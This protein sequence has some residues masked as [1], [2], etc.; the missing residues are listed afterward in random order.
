[1]AS[2]HRTHFVFMLLM[3]SFSTR[4]GAAEAQGA[5][6]DTIIAAAQSLYDAL[7]AGKAEVWERLLTADAIV[8]DEFGRRQTKAEVVKD[9]RPLPAGFSGKLEVR[10][11]H[12]HVYGDTSAVLDC[13]AYEEETVFDQKLV[14]RYKFIFTFVRQGTDWKLAGLAGTTLPTEPPALD[15]PEARLGDYPGTYRWGPE[16]VFIVS[17]TDGKLA[18]ARKA[19][20][21]ATALAPI[22]KDVFMEG[23]DER[24]LIIF[25]RG[26]DGRVQELI[27]RRKFNDLHAKRE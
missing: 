1:M 10:D 20:G 8:L 23:G 22:G 5:I 24:N 7:T 3:V 12:V 21:P 27:E 25:R 26:A 13:E 6:R 18:H 11:A 15:V 2:P 17:V 14:V 4:A 19:G 9:I 16:R